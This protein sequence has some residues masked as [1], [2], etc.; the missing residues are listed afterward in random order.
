MCVCVLN[1]F[2]R[3]RLFV[4]LW[5]VTRQTALSMRFSNQEYWSGLPCPPLADLPKPEIEP[6]SPA[7]ESRFFTSD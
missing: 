3:V 7:W 4:A 1:H 2:S 6:M 5:T